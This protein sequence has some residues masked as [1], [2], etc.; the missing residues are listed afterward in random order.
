[1]GKLH[2]TF[3]VSD[4]GR[5]LMKILAKDLGLTSTAVLE[6]AVRE[7]AAKRGLRQALVSTSPNIENRSVL[8]S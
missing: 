6:L 1:M 8:N 5:E 2:T 3:R 7:L 4:E